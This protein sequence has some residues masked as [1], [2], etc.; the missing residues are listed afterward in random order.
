MSPITLQNFRLTSSRS[1]DHKIQLC[2][3]SH[4]EGVSVPLETFPTKSQPKGSSS[5]NTIPHSCQVCFLQQHSCL[6]TLNAYRILAKIAH[7]LWS[8]LL[9]QPEGVKCIRIVSFRRFQYSVEFP[10]VNKHLEW[11]KLHYR[12]VPAVSP[13]FGFPSICLPSPQ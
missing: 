5:D 11:K 3:N 7:F 12:W 6:I 4:G 2:L 9:M 1:S 13:H 10:E 8:Q